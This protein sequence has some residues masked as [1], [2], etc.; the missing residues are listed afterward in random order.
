ML[1]DAL[2]ALPLCCCRSIALCLS[3]S[4]P[5]S[6][7]RFY[8]SLSLPAAL[9]ALAACSVCFSS[10]C[11]RAVRPAAVAASAPEAAS[12]PW[13]D[14]DVARPARHSLSPPRLS[15]PS[16]PFFPP[17][18]VETYLR[19]SNGLPPFP[20]AFPTVLFLAVPGHS[21]SAAILNPQRV[22]ASASTDF[23]VRLPAAF[24]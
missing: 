13:P 6:L 7:C 3:L 12:L 9:C 1:F 20:I 18:R 10:P 5:L 24:S 16:L 2:V 8:S 21:A 14:P 15:P 19:P 22:R 17:L 4:L 11:A 23:A